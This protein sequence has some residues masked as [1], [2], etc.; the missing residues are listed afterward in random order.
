[1]KIHSID[2]SVNVASSIKN[3][4]KTY[5]DNIHVAS[6]SLDRNLQNIIKEKL[7]NNQN[8]HGGIIRLSKNAPAPPI[9]QLPR[10][11]TRT[12]KGGI[13][14]FNNYSPT[15]LQ[16]PSNALARGPQRIGTAPAKGT[17]ISRS[18]AISQSQAAALLGKSSSSSKK[19]YIARAGPINPGQMKLIPT[20]AAGYGSP[21][22]EFKRPSTGFI[23]P[24]KAKGSFSDKGSLKLTTAGSMLA[25]SPGSSIR[26]STREFSQPPFPMGPPPGFNRKQI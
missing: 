10:P 26:S 13:S 4:L 5:S 8:Q 24:T 9:K 23:S 18:N 25:G 1:M 2:S 6:N 19:E 20:A 17:S 3:P 7:N 21:S 15:A 16:L 11:N 22:T 12:E 14:Y